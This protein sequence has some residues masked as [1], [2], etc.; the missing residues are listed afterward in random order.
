MM[1]HVTFAGDL[2]DTVDNINKFVDDLNLLLNKYK[3]EGLIDKNLGTIDYP[4]D[5]RCTVYMQLESW[6][7]NNNNNNKTLEKLSNQT[8]QVFKIPFNSDLSAIDDVEKRMR[9]N[10]I[11]L[12][13]ICIGTKSNKSR[14]VLKQLDDSRYLD[15]GII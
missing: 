11:K 8:V 9:D 2:L 7:N 10:N 13:V 5:N 14:I 6:C 15:L 12:A 3:I 1:A 4:V